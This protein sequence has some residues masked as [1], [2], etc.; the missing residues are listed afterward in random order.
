MILNILDVITFYQF[1]SSACGN[2]Y[3]NSFLFVSCFTNSLE[4]GL[5]RM[6][7]VPTVPEHL[8]QSR[9]IH[10]VPVPALYCIFSVTDSQLNGRNHW[11]VVN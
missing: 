2:P 8:G 6:G 4:H 11:G 7:I 5:S 3:H 9:M 10:S 1:C